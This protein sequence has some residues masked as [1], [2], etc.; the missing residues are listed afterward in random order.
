MNQT[1]GGETSDERELHLPPFSHIRCLGT[2]EDYDG[3][4]SAYRAFLVFVHE[5]RAAVARLPLVLPTKTGSTWERLDETI[6]RVLHLLALLD[7]EQRIE[8][9]RTIDETIDLY[10]TLHRMHEDGSH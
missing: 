4:E 9:H 8:F 5:G 7:L 6:R 3:Y 1:Q 2:Y 10:F